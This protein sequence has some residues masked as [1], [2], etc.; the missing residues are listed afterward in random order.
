MISKALQANLV[1]VASE[2]H[3]LIITLETFRL[4]MESDTSFILDVWCENDG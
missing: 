2:I 4:F 3:S 1:Y